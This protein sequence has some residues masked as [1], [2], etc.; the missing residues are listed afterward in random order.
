MAAGVTTNRHCVDLQFTHLAVFIHR[1]DMVQTFSRGIETCAGFI[2]NRY[3]LWL[4]PWRLHISSFTQPIIDLHPILRSHDPPYQ[5][6]CWRLPI[7]RLPVALSTT[8][9]RSHE[10]LSRAS[11][12]W[13]VCPVDNEDNGGG[14]TAL[15]PRRSSWRHSLAQRL[16]PSCQTPHRDC[17]GGVGQYGLRH[18][19]QGS[20]RGFRSRLRP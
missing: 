1:S 3:R 6:C 2:Q 15:F 10:L 17:S 18:Q 13:G 11:E 19:P 16:L 8:I 4:A 7:R 12:K 5:R 14:I 9:G 20:A